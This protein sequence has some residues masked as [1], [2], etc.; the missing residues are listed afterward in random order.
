MNEII[1]RGLY[2]IRHGASSDASRVIEFI[3]GY[4]AVLARSE[5]KQLYKAPDNQSLECLE[6]AGRSRCVLHADQTKE[7]NLALSKDWRGVYPMSIAHTWTVESG[8]DP[9]PHRDFPIGDGT[10][11]ANHINCPEKD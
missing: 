10:V 6:I 5:W 9:F 7:L 11:F 1:Q 4:V 3:K 8:A 2:V